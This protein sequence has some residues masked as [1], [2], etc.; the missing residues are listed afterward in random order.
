MSATIPRTGPDSLGAGVYNLDKG[1]S[2]LGEP[3]RLE[4]FGKWASRIII[5]SIAWLVFLLLPALFHPGVRRMGIDDIFADLFL[6]PQR[7]ANAIFYLVV[8]YINY[9]WAIPRFYLRHRYF[10]YI[11]FVLGCLAGFVFFNA[12]VLEAVPSPVQ[13]DAS[14]TGPNGIMQEPANH[15]F[16]ILGPSHNTFLLIMALGASFTLRLYK[17]WRQVAEE[18][19]VAEIAFLKAQMAPHFLF[20]TL[21]AIYSLALTK[22]DDAPDAVLKLSRLLR[23]NVSEA[24]GARVSLV[25]ELDYIRAYMDLQRLRFSEKVNLW[26]EITGDDN[27][28]AQR[29]QIEPFLL[30]PFIENAFKHGVN[31]EENSDIQVFIRLRGDDL[32]MD[33]S[34]RKVTVQRKDEDSTGVGIENTQQ[35]LKLLYGGRHTLEIDDTKNYYT[36]NLQITLS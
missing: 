29:L 18:K 4:N 36:V 21:N 12:I 13:Q 35:R 3:S 20:N 28:E 23:Y 8:F 9:G 30:I 27:P 19:A 6:I 1:L 5:G 34:N 32:H 11:V 26:V 7:R 33:V 14:L 31:S 17:Q 10:W 25:K 15:F 16:R 2:T 22:H 24:K